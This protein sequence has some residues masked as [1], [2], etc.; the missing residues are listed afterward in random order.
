MSL[1]Q[2]HRR[3]WNRSLDKELKVGSRVDAAVAEV[4]TLACTRSRKKNKECSGW[5]S[6]SSPMLSGRITRM[7]MKP[8][9][10]DMEAETDAASRHCS[11]RM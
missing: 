9:H 1:F 4:V 7:E 5:T 6:P 2:G 10:R 8:S 11:E 3:A